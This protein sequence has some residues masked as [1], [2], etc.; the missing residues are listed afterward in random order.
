[1]LNRAGGLRG[2]ALAAAL[3]LAAACAAPAAEPRGEPVASGDHERQ[4]EL[5]GR[6][7]HFLVHVPPRAAA[8]APLPLLLAFH[9][10]GGN[11]RGFRDYAGLDAVADREG[12]AV[13]YP[14]GTG[15]FAR[16]LLTWNAGG[17]C[18]YAMQ[19]GVDDVAFA[20]ALV[21][22]L[23]RE[24][25]LDGARVWA[26][27]HSNG[28]MM[29]HRLAAEASDL[30]A[31]VVPVAGVTPL[32]AFAPEHPVAVLHLHSVDDPR[33]L[34]AG[35]LG[36][37]FPLTGLRSLHESV[38]AQLARWARRNGCASQPREVERRSAPAGRPDA[39]HTA[40]RLDWGP[41]ASGREVAPWRLAGA[42]HGWPGGRPAL[43]ERWVGP[44]TAVVSAAEEIWAFVSRFSRPPASPAGG[45]A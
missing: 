39:G 41:C 4:L 37:P 3:L 22:L 43:P 14:D 1:V 16:R 26:T 8:G 11:A 45:G 36:P 23:A 6:T 13:V 38:E 42:G 12:F 40:V 27:G 18:G 20:R 2:P 29:A 44:E 28:G 5:G 32:A 35:G 33:A 24:L 19:Q 7:R 15:R 17:C 31:A 9:G 10:G 30:V 25:P 34:Y 21:A